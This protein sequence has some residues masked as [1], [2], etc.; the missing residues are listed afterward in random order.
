MAVGAGTKNR[1]LAANAAC[2]R[3][4]GTSIALEN[5]CCDENYMIN[6]E[7]QLKEILIQLKRDESLAISD[8]SLSNLM[9]NHSRQTVEILARRILEI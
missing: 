1:V 9:S 4:I 2:K 6:S 8:E 7:D 5:I 3:V